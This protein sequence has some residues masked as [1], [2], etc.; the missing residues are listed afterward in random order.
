M[1]LR[2]RWG[3]PG[4]DAVPEEHLAQTTW[5]MDVT[6]VRICDVAVFFVETRETLIFTVHYDVELALGLREIAERFVVDYVRT[7]KEPPPEASERFRETLTRLHPQERERK[8]YS[9]AGDSLE[10]AALALREVEALEKALQVRGNRLR[11]LF[12]QTIGDE[13]GVLGRFG[14][15]TWT[16]NRD[17]QR[18]DYEALAAALRARL[19]E[20]GGAEA[21]ETCARLLA[22]HTHPTEGSRVL[23]KKW[24]KLLSPAALAVPA[25]CGEE[26]RLA[27]MA[28]EVESEEEQGENT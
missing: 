5:Q 27:L 16:K 7:G 2:R 21:V 15:I 14:T 13:A 9:H 10:E 17:G 28:G 4:T 11:N 26:T 19:L 22:E 23:R 18:V 24:S 20:A 6:G 3:E 25:L 1:H 8:A 12:R